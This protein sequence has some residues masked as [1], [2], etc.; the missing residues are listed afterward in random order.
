MHFALY[1]F[2]GNG[3]YVNAQNKVV[4]NNASKSV[5][6]EN[7]VLVY[8]EEEA[9]LTIND[10]QNLHSNSQFKLRIKDVSAYSKSAIWVVVEIENKLTEEI[11]LELKPEFIDQISIFTVLDDVVI[12]SVLTG[13]MYLFEDRRIKTKNFIFAINPGEF[14]YYIRVKSDTYLP[15]T[16]KLLG[17]KNLYEEKHFWNF[18]NGLL[19]GALIL[20]ILY[21]LL[22]YFSVRDPVY[23]YYLIFVFFSAL[24]LSYHFGIGTRFFWGVYPVFSKH[25][26]I[27]YGL[28]NI[29]AILFVMRML[30]LASAMPRVYGSLQIMMAFVLSIIFIDL[31]GAVYLSNILLMFVFGSFY[32]LI[33]IIA[34][35]LIKKGDV[36]ARLFSVSFLFP[37]IAFVIFFI[38][39]LHIFSESN[40]SFELLIY[41]GYINIMVLSLV[42]G[43]KINVYSANE[44]QARY[45]E[46]EALKERDRIISVQKIKLE[47]IVEERNK[48]IIHK[49]HELV[50]QQ[51]E[52]EYQINKIERKNT[53]I[54]KVNNQLRSKNE[55]IEEQNID[56]K[57]NKNQL[58]KI[59]ELRTK[60]L[61]KEKERAIAADRLKTTFLNNLSREV[62]TPMNAITG[63][64]TLI[65][66]KS[67][68]IGQ[69]NEYL[70]TII[71]NVDTLLSLID[72][73]VTLSRIQ[74][75]II[76]VKTREIDLKSFLKL[77]ADEF[78]Q[79]LDDSKNNDIVIVTEIADGYDDVIIKSDY[80]KLWLIYKQLMENALKFTEKGVV[81]LGV[82]ID[83][84]LP[85]T[86][87][88]KP[89]D[90]QKSNCEIE[91][92]VKDTGKGMFEQDIDKYI[93]R[94]KPG[95][96][97]YNYKQG[98]LGLAIV[99]GL[100]DVFN[101]KIN[102][103]SEMGKG[104]KFGVTIST[105]LITAN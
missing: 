28:V 72:D 87:I 8:I 94:H 37:I 30:S 90:L 35:L 52:I 29:S 20:A 46:L 6:L 34:L 23:L 44:E 27:F 63:Y 91:F 4:F 64:A 67:I 32:F 93:F 13:S 89:G 45:K 102:V 17:K 97:N 65:V 12:D 10:I 5:G 49:N 43:N 47:K 39:N 11:Y 51:D 3:A 55:K 70:Q 36:S 98:G 96:F 38:Q 21:N 76:K 15:F 79:K 86:Q 103:T 105:E 84:K 69:R 25:I 100:V 78:N 82:N 71:E 81:T 33:F 59:V 31:L 9:S 85:G 24:T 19:F 54:N 26:T 56:L 14:T 99:T 48:E 80:N 2:S 60:E 88:P 57:S 92:F 104:T 41:G 53:E 7:E 66:N 42:V 95:V 1:L 101:G 61:E 62:K 73:I 58:E 77:V 75:G 50:V 40:G 68:S 18:I 22:L 74:A 16:L 83:E